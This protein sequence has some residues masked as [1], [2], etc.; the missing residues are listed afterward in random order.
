M[1]LDHSDVTELVRQAI[2]G[3]QELARLEKRIDELRE[4]R[5]ADARTLVRETTCTRTLISAA[6]GIS[7]PTLDKYL[8][9]GYMTREYLA[10]VHKANRESGRRL[11]DSRDLQLA[12]KEA[13]ILD[14]PTTENPES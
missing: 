10:T 8:A 6:L 1:G 14:A 11:F 4:L 5:A 7:R 13:G 12:M 3:A 9:D 2:D